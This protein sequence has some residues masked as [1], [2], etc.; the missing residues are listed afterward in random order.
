MVAPV[1][2]EDRIAMALSLEL[3]GGR[4]GATARV[5]MRERSAGR[6]V[7][8]EVHGWLDRAAV[9]RLGRTLDDLGAR[10][11]EQLLLDCTEVRHIDYRSVPDLVAALARFEAHAGAPVL[12]GLS[13]YLRNVIRLAGGEERLRCWPSSAD[14]LAAPAACGPGRERAS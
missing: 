8:L 11:I 9:A 5:T 12:C 2:P 4:R 6:V 10:G 14:L 3:S 1:M 13:G 7:L